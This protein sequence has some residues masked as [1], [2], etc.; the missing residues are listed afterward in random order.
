MAYASLGEAVMSVDTTLTTTKREMTD[1]VALTQ[2]EKSE[3]YLESPE[4]AKQEL[5]VLSKN[6]FLVYGQDD[7]NRTVYRVVRR[8]R[9]EEGMAPSFTRA[10]DAKYVDVSKEPFGERAERLAFSSSSLLTPR[11]SLG[12]PWKQKRVALHSSCRAK[13]IQ[14]PA[15]FVP[16]SNWRVASPLSSLIKLMKLDVYI[17]KLPE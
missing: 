10:P 8:E 14:F 11:R 15:R 3:T 17:Q 7:V 16:R 2:R 13:R 12:L 4:T 1:A 9:Y 6:D 5:S